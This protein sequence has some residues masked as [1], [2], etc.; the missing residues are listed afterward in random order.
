MLRAIEPAWAAE[1]L[2]AGSRLVTSIGG[3]FRHLALK[4]RAQQHH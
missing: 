2:A 3:S 4:I 1:R